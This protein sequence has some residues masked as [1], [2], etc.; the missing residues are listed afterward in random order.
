MIRPLLLALTLAAASLE[1]MSLTAAAEPLISA[2]APALPVPQ[3]GMSVFSSDGHNVGSVKSIDATQ[4]GR[5]TALNGAAGGFLGFG[6][7]LF[8][9]PEGRF[10]LIGTVVRVN[11]TAEEVRR[12]PSPGPRNTGRGE[13]VVTSR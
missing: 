2:P 4:D 6:A 9:V 7:R 13:G 3:P 10:G 11:L 5:V 1:A 8:T 12:L